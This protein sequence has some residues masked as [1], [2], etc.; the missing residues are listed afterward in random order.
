[1]RTKYLALDYSAFVLGLIAITLLSL[2]RVG[3]GL[4]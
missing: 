4:F 3:R 2:E 1:M